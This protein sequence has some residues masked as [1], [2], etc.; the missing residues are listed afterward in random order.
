MKDTLEELKARVEKFVLLDFEDM[1]DISKIKQKPLNKK[2]FM[3]LA[4]EVRETFKEHKEGRLIEKIK[5]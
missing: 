5:R 3:K 4:K 1:D 2:K